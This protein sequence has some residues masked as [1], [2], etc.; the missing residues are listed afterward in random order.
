MIELPAGYA[1][2]PLADRDVDD[3]VRLV[4]A[5]ERHDTGAQMYERADLV[6]DLALAD[7][8]RD[9][10][11][12]RGAGQRDPVGWG[13]VVRGRSRWADVHP[14][15]RGRGLGRALVRWSV[16]AARAVGADRIGQTIA[17]GRADAERLMRACGASPVRTAWILVRDH[18]PAGPAPVVPGAGPP[19]GVALREATPADADAALDM[20]ER[21]FRTWP[22]REPSSRA[23]WQA[24]VTGREGFGY[25]QLQLA[26]DAA[27][28]PVGA[29][30]LLVDGDELWVDKLATDP[31]WQGRGI[32]R[33]LLA[34]ASELAHS[35][36]LARTM[37]STDS[38][39]GAL[40]FYERLGMC[41][42]RSFTH[43]AIPLTDPGAGG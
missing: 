43:W 29:A 15:H 33:A 4:R 39:T 12:L 30:F 26:V 11:V 2:A 22:D 21:A 20:M 34:R 19:V 7:R 10:V 6:G 28:R 25:E 3:V 38:T 42:Q 23:V 32:G 41:V 24:M 9:S 8:A 27:G 17:D 1:A 40:P 37:L 31:D 36:G 13:L 14:E 16:G 35:R 5:C 18:D